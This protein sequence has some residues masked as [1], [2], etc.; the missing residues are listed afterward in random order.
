MLLMIYNTRYMHFEKEGEVDLDKAKEVVE[1]P[2]YVL[3]HSFSKKD[4]GISFLYQW[5]ASVMS[6]I[7]PFIPFEFE[8]Y[9]V[10]SLSKLGYDLIDDGFF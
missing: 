5:K 9:V 1:F 8:N 7:I 6:G 3:N 2:D 10:E 4:F